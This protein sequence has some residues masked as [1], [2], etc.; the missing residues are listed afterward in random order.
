MI[1]SGGHWTGP[2]GHPGAPQCPGL[3]LE[4]RLGALAPGNT[5]P[6]PSMHLPVRPPLTPWSRRQEA[7]PHPWLRH[8]SGAQASCLGPP[9]TL[10][11]MQVQAHPQ[12]APHPVLVPRVRVADDLHQ[13]LGVDAADPLLGRAGDSTGAVSLRPRGPHLACRA[14]S[15]RRSE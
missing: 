3:A 12:P 8:S 4:A 9:P 5:G 13:V 2:L 11:G 6:P 15:E 1:V 7:G 14:C 10:H